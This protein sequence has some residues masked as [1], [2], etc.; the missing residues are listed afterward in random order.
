MQRV[1]MYTEQAN[2][3]TWVRTASGE[4]NTFA[5][6]LG[7]HNGAVCVTCGY[8]HCHHCAASIDPCPLPN[9]RAVLSQDALFVVAQDNDEY[10]LVLTVMDMGEHCEVDLSRE[11]AEQLRDFLTLHLAP[12]NGE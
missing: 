8:R 10:P 3:H 7:K 2:G 5:Y 1:K 6:Q 12:K 9:P 11:E 4:I